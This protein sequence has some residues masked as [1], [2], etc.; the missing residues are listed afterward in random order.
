MIQFEARFS[1]V[2][3][4]SKA[5]ELETELRRMRIRRERSVLADGAADGAAGSSGDGADNGGA[6]IM[7][8]I[9]RFAL[10]VFGFFGAF[11]LEGGA[12]DFFSLLVT[13]E[14]AIIIPLPIFLDFP[15]SLE[16]F[17]EKCYMIDNV[18]REERLAPFT[19]HFTLE[20]QALQVLT[21]DFKFR[22]LFSEA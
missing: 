7:P 6:F 3:G 20:R 2:P 9:P 8:F 19:M 16:S 22:A 15:L 21:I 11:A 13:L 18:R 12:L 10:F 1:G 5:S 14:D 4:A 17:V